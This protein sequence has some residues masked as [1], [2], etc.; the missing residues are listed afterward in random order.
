[1]AR[2]AELVGLVEAD[3]RAVG[4]VQLVDVVLACGSG[5]TSP[6]ASRGASTFC[7]WNSVSLRSRGS[8]VRSAWQR[9]QGYVGRSG[10]RGSMETRPVAPARGAIVC[11]RARLSP[12]LHAAADERREHARGSKR[13]QHGP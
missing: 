13:R 5:S 6:S 10:F 4:E 1:M 12:M 11:R 2:A 9:E 3:Q 7:V 8:G